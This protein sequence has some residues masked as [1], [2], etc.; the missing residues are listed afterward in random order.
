MVEVLGMGSKP[1][2]GTSLDT[3]KPT[4]SEYSSRVGTNMLSGNRKQ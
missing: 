1:G 2:K 3:G 4:K